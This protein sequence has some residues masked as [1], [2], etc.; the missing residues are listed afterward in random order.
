MKAGLNWRN[1]LS[2]FAATS[3]ILAG[4]SIAFVTI[5]ISSDVGG[6]TLFWTIRWGDVAV[7]VLGLTSAT[8]IAATELYLRAK[9]FDPWDLPERYEDYMKG[10]DW[11]GSPEWNEEWEDV[12]KDQLESCKHFQ[13]YAQDTYNTSIFLLFI[14]L[15]FVIGSYDIVAAALVS[16]TGIALEIFQTLIPTNYGSVKAKGSPVTNG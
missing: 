13:R 6:R 4:F 11:K 5:V 14:G 7:L 9:S 3:G 12:R 16:L 2:D 1:T 10:R 15:F 8:F